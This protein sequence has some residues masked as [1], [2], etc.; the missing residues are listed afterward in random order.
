MTTAGRPAWDG[1][2]LPPSATARI[3]RTKASGLT[4]SMLSI[5]GGLGLE[6]VGFVPVS[7]VMGTSVVQLGWV[8]YGGCG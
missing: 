4:T 3:S 7:E 1:R 8:G 2:G 5:G 6:S